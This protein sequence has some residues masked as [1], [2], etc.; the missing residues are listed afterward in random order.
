MYVCVYVCMYVCM[1][2]CVSAP[3]FVHA[4]HVYCESVELVS[5]ALAKS[6]C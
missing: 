3:I 6:D 5:S 4:L 2:V 1:Y